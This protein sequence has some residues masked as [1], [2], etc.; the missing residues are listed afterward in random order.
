MKSM[1]SDKPNSSPVLAFENGLVQAPIP[2][3][4]QAAGDTGL[5]LNG[6]P[7]RWTLRHVFRI[8][9]WR[10]L[11]T[12]GLFNLENLLRL[13]YPFVLGLAINGL[14][15]SSYL[16][17]IL[18]I[19]LHLSHLLIGALRRMYD[20]RA[21]T[22]IYT[23]LATQ[24]VLEQ[25]GREVE[26]SRVAARSALSRVFVDFFERDVPSV[27]R[28]LYSVVGALVMLCVYDWMLLPFCLALVIPTYL[29]NS[30]FGR[31]TLLFNRLLNDQFEQEV[32]VI[33]RS[34]PQEV[35]EHYSRLARWR[36]KL[37]DWV[38]IN[39]SL[40][41]LFVL[42]LMAA[43][44]V[45]FCTVPG[46]SAGDIF[47]VFRYLTLFTMGLDSVPMVVQQISRLRDVGRRMRHGH[48]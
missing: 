24:L 29:V 8:Y 26:T 15:H 44:L 39:F 5:G 36:V 16:G 31:K 2:L 12:Y 35:H 10:I 25:R 45:R 37:S 4:L 20:T 3:P 48:T 1:R 21:F 33:G 46:V 14:L 38:A 13:S 32:E 27:V 17:L 43:A 9:R 23:D 34:Q 7:G 28:A 19:V 41:E 6:A 30:A 11:L 18:F 22:S 47:A 40:M 42:G